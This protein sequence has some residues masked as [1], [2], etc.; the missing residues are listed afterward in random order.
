MI[1]IFSKEENVDFNKGL[2]L[3]G[4]YVDLRVTTEDA[5]RLKFISESALELDS[6]SNQYEI[7]IERLSMEV[8]RILNYYLSNHIDRAAILTYGYEESSYFSGVI[9]T[10]EESI[11]TYYSGFYTAALSLMFISLEAYLRNL[12]GWKPGDKDIS[13]RQLK[14]SVN[15]LPDNEYRSLCQDVINNIYSRYDPLAPSKFYFNRHGLLHGLRIEKSEY[16]QM[17]CLRL[18]NL[19]DLLSFC[20]GGRRSGVINER[21]ISLTHKFERYYTNIN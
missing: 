9:D 14:L 8:F 3:L 17:N 15:N 6:Y 16:D 5:M 10:I 7:E 11:C 2:S 21:F 13:F 20:D 12:A 18:L 19:M 4:W 1:D